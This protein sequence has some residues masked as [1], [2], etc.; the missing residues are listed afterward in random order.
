MYVCISHRPYGK[1]EEGGSEKE[2]G[3]RKELT[4]RMSSLLTSATVAPHGARHVAHPLT[5]FP[6]TEKVLLTD[7]GTT[8]EETTSGIHTSYSN[9]PGPSP[10]ILTNNQDSLDIHVKPRENA[11]P[12]QILNQITDSKRNRYSR[13][14]TRTERDLITH[15]VIAERVSHLCKTRQVLTQKMKKEDPKNGNYERKS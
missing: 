7:S 3:K 11:A 9:Q 15:P 8:T 1:E 12:P 13:E 5:H 10:H 6:P 4:F 2:N 14:H